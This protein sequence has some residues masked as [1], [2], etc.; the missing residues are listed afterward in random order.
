MDENS[1]SNPWKL[2]FFVN[3]PEGEPW[4]NVQSS[5]YYTKEKILE[6]QT[7][8]SVMDKDAKRNP[9]DSSQ[10]WAQMN[11][12]WERGSDQLINH[13]E[14][15]RQYIKELL[16]SAL[17]EGVQYVE[18]RRFLYQMFEMSTDSQY[19]ATN[20]KK[21]IGDKDGGEEIEFVTMLVDEFIQA[22]PKFIGL[23]FI[24]Q[25][26][27]F[28]SKKEIQKQIEKII[29]MHEKYPRVLVGCDLVS[30]ED[31]GNSHLFFAENLLSIYDD[32]SKMNKVDIYLHTAETS[33][34]DDQRMSLDPMDPSS[35]L[36]NTYD[37][38]ALGS[39]RVGHGLGYIK[40]PYLM[41]LLKKNNIAVEVC[42]VSNQLLGLIPDLR[43]HPGLNYHRNGVPIVLGSDDPG[44]FG[45][46]YFTIDWYMIFFG[47]GLDLADLKVI[48]TNSINYSA[49]NKE[50]KEIAFIKLNETWME[51]IDIMKNEAC[52]KTF[53]KKPI[54][55]KMFPTEGALSQPTEVKLFGSHFESG[56]CK[57]VKCKFGEVIVDAK[58]ESVNL[59]SCESPPREGATDEHTV[60][61][62]VAL[63]GDNFIDTLS[64]FTYKYN[65]YSHPFQTS[66]LNMCING[67][68]QIF[69]GCF[70][71]YSWLLVFILLFYYL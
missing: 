61:V 9:S 40:H 39:N 52:S 59:I 44:T 23:K 36:Q 34:P 71:S 42:P 32:R 30:E 63:D 31:N 10:R 15:K 65:F 26:R 2:E 56:I 5:T 3:P 51:Y 38:I 12:L 33:F 41:N 17:E 18:T 21:Y 7:F 64:N 29:Q 14:I 55:A 6:K 53:Q 46:D 67:S 68:A 70:V 57:S 11:T 8:M 19:K 50:E 69:H 60:P 22:N 43:N 35:A 66:S 16:K 62:F 58:L 45:N 47:W 27:R 49:M 25:M 24:I 48:V 1:T 28:E 54:F 4:V 37:A 20:G 13:K